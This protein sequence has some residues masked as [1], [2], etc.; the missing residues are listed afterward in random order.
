MS[1]ELPGDPPLELLA[2]TGFLQGFRSVDLTTI[3]HYFRV[4]DFDSGEVVFHKE[5]ASLDLYV[6]IS[7]QVSIQDPDVQSDAAFEIAVCGKGSVFGEMSFIDSA[8]RSMDAICL[9][10]TT[11]AVLSQE[12]F[13][14]LI[15][16][17][18]FIGAFVYRNVAAELSQRLRT[19]NEGVRALTRSNAELVKAMAE[20]HILSALQQDG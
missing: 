5:D 12:D 7:G 1:I 8:P 9:Q 13:F 15:E 3:A 17:H 2:G 14:L 10:S 20:Q 18:P 16:K 4:V 6:V 19:A 11:L